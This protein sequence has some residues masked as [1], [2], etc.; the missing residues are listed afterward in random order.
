MSTSACALRPL[1]APLHSLVDRTIRCEAWQ[2]RNA[3]LLGGS[4]STSAECDRADVSRGETFRTEGMLHGAVAHHQQ[5][6]RIPGLR[7]GHVLVEGAQRRAEDVAGT[8]PKG[9]LTSRRSRD[10]RAPATG[11]HQDDLLDEMVV[12]RTCPRWVGELD[13][14][15]IHAAVT[16]QART[17]KPTPRPAPSVAATGT[18]TTDRRRSDTTPSA[19]PRGSRLDEKSFAVCR[20]KED[21]GIAGHAVPTPTERGATRGALPK[22]GA[23][24]HGIHPHGARPDRGE[25]ATRRGHPTPSAACRRARTPAPPPRTRHL[26][27][28]TSRH[29]GDGPLPTSCPPKRSR[30]NT[31]GRC[32]LP[33]DTRFWAR[34]RYSTGAWSMVR[35]VGRW[36]RRRRPREPLR[37]AHAPSLTCGNAGE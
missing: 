16:S 36:R 9:V 13:D 17:Q 30:C 14:R 3:G 29:R 10:R 31:S 4:D 12:S 7:L 11:Q 28:G 15:H 8:P 21:G 1:H 6:G 32:R 23:R 19:G 5:S 34:P 18:P 37:R 2:P 26:E 33:P 22:T 25:T 24:Q 35:S 20:W 27:A